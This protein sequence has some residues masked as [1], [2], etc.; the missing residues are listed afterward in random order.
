MEHNSRFVARKLVTGGFHGSYEYRQPRRYHTSATYPIEGYMGSDGEE[1]QADRRS[2]KVREH[3]ERRSTG[4]TRHWTSAWDFP[5]RQCGGCP[6]R[7]L[8]VRRN[9]TGTIVSDFYGGDELEHP[10]AFAPFPA[11]NIGTDYLSKS[12]E[13]RYGN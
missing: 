8:E 10:F 4:G 9:R 12:D 2:H 11:Y 6:Q 1:G 13:E 3:F 5:V 7:R